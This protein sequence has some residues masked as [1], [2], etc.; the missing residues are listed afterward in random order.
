MTDATTVLVTGATLDIGRAVTR[1]LV[2]NGYRVFGQTD[3]G[4]DGADI[5]HALGAVP[6]YGDG[7]RKGELSSAIKAAKPDIV[8][9]LLP[10]RANTLLHDGLAWRGFEKVLRLSTQAL[11]DAA[12]EN[13]VK[14]IVHTSYG[15]LY[16]NAQNA[17]EGT[18]RRFP[19]KDDVFDAASDAEEIVILSDIPACIL[20]LGW[21]YGAHERDLQLYAKSINTGRPYY[22]GSSHHKA[23]F[24]HAN[25]A[26]KAVVLAAE[27][28][29]DG[30]VYNI[31]DNT[32]VNFGKFIDT[33]TDK[34]GYN[35]VPKLPTFA[36]KLLPHISDEQI[37]LLELHGTLSSA[38]ARE[39]LG[40][41]P[42]YPSYDE[43][44]EQALRVWRAEMAIAR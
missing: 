35:R 33:L 4:K 9:N 40:W 11:V 43:G 16:G 37:A 32:P 36:A 15:F 2:L 5:L 19:L 34:L 28:R 14:F 31:A 25:D 26:A 1:Q 12:E 17:T 20:R 23:S 21:L 39:E 30:E 6:F 44:L 3:L 29:T 13:G 22:A 7:T 18:P 41:S 10:Q 24:V 42:E 38:K 27:K 8:I